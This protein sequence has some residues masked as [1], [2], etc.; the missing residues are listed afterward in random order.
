MKQVI[1]DFD[2]AQIF[3][4][5][6]IKLG[7]IVWKRKPDNSE[8]QNAFEVM[9]EYSKKHPMFLPTKKFPSIIF[10]PIITFLYAFY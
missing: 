7:T 3:H 4:D 6:S 1:F 5:P 9:I 10:E 8:Y 2:Y